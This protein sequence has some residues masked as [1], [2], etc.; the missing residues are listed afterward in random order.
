MGRSTVTAE[1]PLAAGSTVMG[2]RVPHVTGETPPVATPPLRRAYVL[3]RTAA[4]SPCRALWAAAATTRS[5][6]RQPLRAATPF[7]LKN[8]ED[9]SSTANTDVSLTRVLRALVRGLQQIACWMRSR[10][11]AESRRCGAVVDSVATGTPPS[12][13]LMRPPWRSPHT[14][15]WVQWSPSSKST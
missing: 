10:T 3:V 13:I 1:A 5:A 11:A 12:T 15:S 7:G 8:K 9:G 6:T 4:Q 14:I 2:T